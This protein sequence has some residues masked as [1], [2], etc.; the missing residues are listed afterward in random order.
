VFFVGESCGC[1]KYTKLDDGRIQALLDQWRG[2][3]IR[4]QEWE[5]ERTKGKPAEGSARY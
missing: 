1:G 4:L 3:A 2:E 5:E